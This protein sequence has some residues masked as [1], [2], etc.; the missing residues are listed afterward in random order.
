MKRIIFPAILSFCIF[1][2]SEPV[3]PTEAEAKAAAA[4]LRAPPKEIVRPPFPNMANAFWGKQVLKELKPIEKPTAGHLPLWLKAWHEHL[5]GKI[6]I[7]KQEAWAYYNETDKPEQ[8]NTALSLLAVSYCLDWSSENYKDQLVDAVGLV[9]LAGESDK[10]T[11]LGQVARAFVFAKAGLVHRGE[12]IIKILNTEKSSTEDIHLM[13]AMTLD[14]LGTYNDDYVRFLDETISKKPASLRAKWMKAKLLNRWGAYKEAAK[15][16]KQSKDPNIFIRLTLAASLMGQD[17]WL[18]AKDLLALSEDARS[19]L[20]QVT[21]GKLRYLEAK[22]ALQL[23]EY[24]SYKA[25]FSQLGLSPLF[26]A[27]RNSL[28][29]LDKKSRGLSSLTVEDLPKPNRLPSHL[30]LEMVTLWLEWSA[31]TGTKK[32]FKDASK[33]ALA[34]GVD[35]AFV[36][37]TEAQLK[38]KMASQSNDPKERSALLKESRYLQSEAQKCWPRG[39]ISQKGHWL[40]AA[41]RALIDGANGWAARKL[42][43]MGRVWK[44]EPVIQ[45]LMARAQLGQKQAWQQ[46][47]KV[48]PLAQRLSSY[49]IKGLL[50]LAPQ[51]LSKED[52]QALQKLAVTA[53]HPYIVNFIGA[54][55][56]PQHAGHDH[57]KGH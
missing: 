16:L 40:L 33:K 52:R 34:L 43:R 3:G 35:P 18:A 44:R 28:K 23:R 1:G 50:K 9:H 17:K 7:L 42:E 11:L 45:A 56:S 27:E 26:A 46:A 54:Q 51:N 57:G 20:T 32:Y 41:R 31:A 2:C 13:K 8:K 30:R 21:L 24:G 6:E 19:S 36:Y 10:E 4:A 15:I 37:R 53:K 25:H 49:D 29:A 47:L 48:L 55:L 22:T 38:K 12:T 14:V 39:L 5:E